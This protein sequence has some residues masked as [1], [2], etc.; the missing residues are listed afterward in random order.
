ML[1]V[2]ELV[3][4]CYQHIGMQYCFESQFSRFKEAEILLLDSTKARESLQWQPH[5]SLSQTI[6]KILEWYLGVADGADV[7]LLTQAQIHNYMNSSLSETG[8]C[9]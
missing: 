3:Q 5:W 8:A 7:R 6:E 1:T 9:L 4:R 2:G